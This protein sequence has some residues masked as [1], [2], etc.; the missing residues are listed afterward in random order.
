MVQE[1]LGDGKGSRPNLVTEEPPG[2]VLT[3]FPPLELLFCF[4]VLPTSISCNHYL[5]IIE[6]ILWWVLNLKELFPRG[7]AQL[8][9]MPATSTP[10]PPAHFQPNSILSENPWHSPDP[11]GKAPRAREVGVWR[12]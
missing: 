12:K 10:T 4:G 9:K 5:T 1:V 2:C 3:H 11:E 7:P 8:P 6:H